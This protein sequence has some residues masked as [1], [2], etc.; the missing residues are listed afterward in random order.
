[1]YVLVDIE[2]DLWNCGL[3]HVIHYVWW[4]KTCISW[5]YLSLINTTGTYVARLQAR[6]LH[7]LIAFV[8]DF[9]K[10]D[11]EDITFSYFQRGESGPLPN[12]KSHMEGMDAA[13]VSVR[14]ILLDPQQQSKPRPNIPKSIAFSSSSYGDFLSRYQFERPIW[15]QTKQPW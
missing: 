5:F 6:T 8:V 1:M 3:Q 2:I 4:S 12:P 9:V 14:R 15:V 11:I 7:R 10:M 13:V